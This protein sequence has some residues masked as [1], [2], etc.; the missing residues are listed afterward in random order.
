VR[1]P[2]GETVT[3]VRASAT[4]A[5]PYGNPVNNWSGA[6]RTTVTGCAVAPRTSPESGGPDNPVAIIGL[7][8]YAP[9][10]TDIRATDRIEARGETWEVDG[11]PGDWRSPFTGTE[12]GVEVALRR[13]ESA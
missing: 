7:L 9:S 4:S 3:I 11:I 5:D 2:H 10:G 1:F 13:S 8:V 12:F 6:T